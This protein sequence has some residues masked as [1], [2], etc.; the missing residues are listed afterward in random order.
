MLKTVALLA[1]P[2]VAPFE[3]GVVCEIFGI[4]RS[5][6]GGPCF[7]FT[8]ATADPGPVRT[9]LGF[10]LNITDGLEVDRKSTRLNS[11]HLDTSRMPSSA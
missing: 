6:S 7:D 8:I 10:T 3:F 9:S 11:S 1:L 2:G 4:D 5:E